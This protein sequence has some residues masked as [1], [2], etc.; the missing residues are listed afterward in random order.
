MLKDWIELDEAVQ[1]DIVPGFGKRLSGI[2]EKCL[3]E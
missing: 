3:F 1:H 2:L